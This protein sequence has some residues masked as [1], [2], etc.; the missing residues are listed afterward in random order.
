[1]IASQE[2]SIETLNDSLSVALVSKIE[3]QNTIDE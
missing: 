1:M 2:T 3:S